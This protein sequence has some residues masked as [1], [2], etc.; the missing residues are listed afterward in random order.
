VGHRESASIQKDD[1]NIETGL[2]FPGELKGVITILDTKIE[3]DEIRILP[4]NVF[5][6]GWD[7]CGSSSH[8]IPKAAEPGFDL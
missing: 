7:R 2:N 4:F 6:N 8:L 3:Q 5:I 1:W